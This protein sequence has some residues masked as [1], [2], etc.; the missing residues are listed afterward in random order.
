MTS[1]DGRYRRNWNKLTVNQRIGRESLGFGVAEAVS[2]VT[3]LGVVAVADQLIPQ[4]IQKHTY[5]AIGKAL[6]PMFLDPYEHAL[7]KY[8]KI[9]E[10]E[11]DESKP[12]Q[13]RAEELAKLV[14]VFGSAWV[15]SMAAK[16]WTRRLFEPDQ[17]SANQK[18]LSFSGKVS[19]TLPWNWS[20]QER[21]IFSADEGV[22][23]GAIYL[24]NNQLAPG[25]DDLIKKC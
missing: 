15:V 17:H 16:L 4:T 5:K 1:N 2:M 13:Q 12:R 21:M 25:T 19:S 22:H 9:E 8:C 3:S 14:V 6:E 20:P 18:K 23:Y 11:I 7:K 10:C 24:M